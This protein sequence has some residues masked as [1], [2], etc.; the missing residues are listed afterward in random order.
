MGFLVL[1]YEI[2]PPDDPGDLII[3]YVGALLGSLGA[4]WIADWFI[5]RKLEPGSPSQFT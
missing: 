5:W 2:V 1:F 3:G 4:I